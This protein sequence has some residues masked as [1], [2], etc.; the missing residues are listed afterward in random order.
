MTAWDSKSELIRYA[1]ACDSGEGWNKKTSRETEM[2]E[3]DR[4]VPAFA[5]PRFV[6]CT[7]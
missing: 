1:R 2:G 5:P 7:G 6:T 4:G 3:N